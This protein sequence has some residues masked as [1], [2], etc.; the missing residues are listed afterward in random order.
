[1]WIQSNRNNTFS[2]EKKPQTETSL[3]LEDTSNLLALMG[4]AGF[5][6]E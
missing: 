2:A 6:L 3:V 1:M 4:A 5:Y